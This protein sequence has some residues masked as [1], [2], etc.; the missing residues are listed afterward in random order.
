MRARHHLSPYFALVGVSTMSLG[1]VF[2]MLGEFRDRLGVS[3]TGLGVM[4]A[5]G[6][7]AALASQIGLARYADRGHGKVMIRIGLVTMVASH[8]WMAAATELWHLIGAR[9]ALGIGL[10]LIFPSVRRIVITYDPAALGRNL[11]T[12]GA[13]D[14]SGFAVGPILAAVFV[15]LIGFRSP[16]LVL[17]LLTAL[18]VPFVARL[19]V[20]TG[21]TSREKGVV[22]A[23]LRKRAMRAS[24]LVAAGWFAMIGAFESV[25]ALLLTD[26]GAETWVIG[27]T[28]TI[29]AL[30]MIALAP[31]GGRIAQ[32]FGALRVA[33]FGVLAAIPCVIAYGFVTSVFVLGVIALLQGVG[34]AVAFPATQVGAAVAAEEHQ[35]ATAQGLLSATLELV[36]G[37]VALAAAATYEEWGAEP[38]FVG[39]GGLMLAGVLA[40]FGVARP[41]VLSRDALVYGEEA[42]VAS[43]REPAVPTA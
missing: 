14:I 37:I 21:A 32:R 4:V 6:F 38:V 17:G 26:L 29:V 15:E 23:L 13:F 2:T 35:L 24:L 18:F 33:G 7:F 8:L 16:F 5:M 10:G 9:M 19:P 42:V 3:E 27:L 12:L 25:W 1:A 28:L 39:I 11:G 43:T 36:A 20:D 34:D 40:A 22:R 31:V 30:P 41:L